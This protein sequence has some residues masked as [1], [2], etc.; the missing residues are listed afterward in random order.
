MNLKTIFCIFCVASVMNLFA[1]PGFSKSPKSVDELVKVTGE[2]RFSIDI[3]Q[4]E[5]RRLSDSLTSLEKLEKREMDVNDL[6]NAGDEVAFKQAASAIAEIFKSSADRLIEM[7]AL[8]Y[9]LAALLSLEDTRR[10]EEALYQSYSQKFQ[11]VYNSFISSF[12]TISPQIKE[13]LLACKSE[14]C[15]ANISD[16][17]RELLEFGALLN[18]GVNVHQLDQWQVAWEFKSPFTKAV[19]ERTFELFQ[20]DNAK[21]SVYTTVVAT[22]LTPFVAA[23]R[24]S[25]DVGKYIGAFLMTVPTSLHLELEAKPVDMNVQEQKLILDDLEY[26]LIFSIVNGVRIENVRRNYRYH[27]NTLACT[28]DADDLSEFHMLIAGKTKAQCHNL[29]NEDRNSYSAEIGTLG[30]GLFIGGSGFLIIIKS[31]VSITPEGVWLG[32]TAKV[33]ALLGVEQG[34]LI[35]KY[36]SLA[37]IV[38]VGG[39]IGAAAG[40]S[41][42]TIEVSGSR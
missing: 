2:P 21:V 37:T 18:R 6:F 13:A 11:G 29:R 40:L 31:L 15:V 25:V 23:A 14:L 8:I 41:A 24:K 17:Q 22:A 32:E 20:P 26:R 27:V 1:I 34:F 42:L 39:G 5:L 35:G 3:D 33:A 36:G 12:L 9:R 16:A 19:L 28:V 38:G 10:L 30:P 7:K 4:E